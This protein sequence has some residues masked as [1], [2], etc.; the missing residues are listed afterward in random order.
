MSFFDGLSSLFIS[1]VSNI[2]LVQ[3][4]YDSWLVVLSVVVAASASFFALRL[5]ETARNITLD[6][7]RYV[8]QFSGAVI[9]AGGIWS[10]HFIGMLA[11]TM[12]H[13]MAYDLSL[14]ILSLFPALIAG[15]IVI[16]SLARNE[17][18]FSAILRSGIFVGVGIGAMHYIGMAAMD[19]PLTL[20]YNPYLFLISI[21]VAVCLAVVA[22]VSRSAMR[23]YFPNMSSIRIK[24]IAAVIMGCAIAGMHYTG[25]AAAYFIDTAPNSPVHIDVDDRYIGYVV[26]AFSMIIFVMAVSVSAQ[27][28]YRQ[29]LVDIRS[30]EG[31]LKAILET[32]TDGLLTINGCG[33][34][35]EVNPAALRIFGW[36]QAELLGQSIKVLMLDES[37]PNYD[38][39]LSD[40]FNPAK[41]TVLGHTNETWVKHKSGRLFPIQLGVGRIESDDGEPFISLMC[42]T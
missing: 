29:M 5:A 36:S 8:A 30:S 7:Y 4:Q 38:S 18:T 34:I 32:A 6:R 1:D 13:P 12:P 3:G 2:S 22:L 35:Q 33:I 40:Y 17:S 27:L 28:R 11:F 14:T 37:D 10:M 42:P 21:F 16:K 23:K 15:F 20:K 19:M 24:M 9:L 31:R 41:S 39:L 26:A 25:M